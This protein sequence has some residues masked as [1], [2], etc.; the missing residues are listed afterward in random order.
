MARRGSSKRLVGCHPW[1]MALLCPQLRLDAFPPFIWGEKN[2]PLLTHFHGRDLSIQG[3]SCTTLQATGESTLGRAVGT[4]RTEQR[5]IFGG[6]GGL[7]GHHANPAASPSPVPLSGG[8]EGP[9]KATGG[10]R[11]PALL[12]TRVSRQQCV[13]QTI[14]NRSGFKTQPKDP[15]RAA[16]PLA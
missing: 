10:G 11:V 4:R 1:Q 13:S 16:K 2:D 6:V 14:F 7:A 9:A 12:V 15:G 3:K 8:T 5:G